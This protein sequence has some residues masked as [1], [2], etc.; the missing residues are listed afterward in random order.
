MPCQSFRSPEAVSDPLTLCLASSQGHLILWIISCSIWFTVCSQCIGPTMLRVIFLLLSGF[1][2]CPDVGQW[3]GSVWPVPRQSPGTRGPT[4]EATKK[5][6]AKCSPSEIFRGHFAKHS[7][8]S[9][10]GL[11]GVELQG[12]HPA[13]LLGRSSSADSL[14]FPAHTHQT[15]SL[16]L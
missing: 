10:E 14:A 13:N 9:R 6:G 1:P 3:L 4:R 12:P 8:S 16:T 5:S 15:V 2:Q 11:N 7:V